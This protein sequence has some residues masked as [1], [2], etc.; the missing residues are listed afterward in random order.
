MKVDRGRDVNRL[1]ERVADFGDPGTPVPLPDAAVPLLRPG[2]E[3]GLVGFSA[4]A[5]QG[6]RQRAEGSVTKASILRLGGSVYVVRFGGGGALLHS[7][8]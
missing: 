7:Q 4:A 3:G 1:Q 6:K 5:M 8:L 2:H